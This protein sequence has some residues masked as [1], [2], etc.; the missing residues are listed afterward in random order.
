MAGSI[1]QATETVKF[2]TG[3]GAKY[4]YEAENCHQRVSTNILEDKGIT[5]LEG[6]AYQGLLK[7]KKVQPTKFHIQL[8]GGI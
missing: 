3:Q 2:E 7:K 5:V 8:L 6:R 1:I 4:L